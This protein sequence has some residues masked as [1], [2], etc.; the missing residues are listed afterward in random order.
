M[1]VG[2]HS[3][4]EENRALQ[5]VKAQIERMRRDLLASVERQAEIA[6]EMT[7]FLPADVRCRILANIEEIRARLVAFGESQDRS[8]ADS[9]GGTGSSANPG[10]DES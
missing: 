6:D 8:E 10:S 3:S 2:K 5:E 1:E 9:A 7:R 4:T